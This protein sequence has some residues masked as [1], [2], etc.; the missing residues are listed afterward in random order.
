MKEKPLKIVL[1]MDLNDLQTLQNVLSAYLFL[2]RELK[3]IEYPQPDSEIVKMRIR[4]HRVT[5]R[6]KAN[7]YLKQNLIS[8]KSEKTIMHI[9]KN[10]IRRKN[11]K[12][13]RKQ[14]ERID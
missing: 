11:L 9:K 3:L 8:E 7:I 14:N 6:L 10:N 2:T 5:S 12:T 13:L 4:L 1:I